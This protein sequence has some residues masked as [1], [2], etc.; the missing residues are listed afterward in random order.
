MKWWLSIHV[1]QLLFSEEIFTYGKISWLLAI[2][3]LQILCYCFCRLGDVLSSLTSKKEVVPY[4][5]SVLTKVLADSIGN[6][7]FLVYEV[8]LGQN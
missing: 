2:T 8:I 3:S 1:I 5:N 6:A 4:E 7:I